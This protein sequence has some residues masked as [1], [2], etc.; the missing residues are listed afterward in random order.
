MTAY[1]LALVIGGVILVVCPTSMDRV[2]EGLT[3][4]SRPGPFAALMR[5]WYN[6]DGG[7]YAYNLLP[8][9]HC[10][11]STMAYIA[12]AGR[13]EVGKGFRCYSFVTMLL[14]FCATVFVKQHFFLDVVAGI[15]VAL[16]SWVLVRYV[17]NKK[18]YDFLFFCQNIWV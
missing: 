10:L 9:F 5:S 6:I 3:D 16:V 14:I 11:N 15:G 4:P 1:T 18:S 17:F 13:P 8:S 12:V 2:A 7:R